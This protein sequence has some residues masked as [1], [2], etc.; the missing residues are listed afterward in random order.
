[1]TRIITFIA[2]LVVSVL[3]A[4]SKEDVLMKEAVTLFNQN[5]TEKATTLFEQIVE[6]KETD[7]LPNYY[8]A[9]INVTEAIENR[10]D[11]VKMKELL[12][13]AQAYQDK[14]NALQPENAEILLVQALI[15][16]GWIIYN[17]IINGQKLSSDVEYLYKKAT[18]L[19]PE[20]PRVILQYATYKMGKAR[21]FGQDVTPY[22]DEIK[23][24]IKLFATFKPESN[25]HPN[26]G[27]EKAT[28][29]QENCT[30]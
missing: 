3:S 2:L 21:Y 27:L 15:H 18:E 4:Q 10:E 24:A 11:L 22:C 9:L 26:W 1:M 29:A 5:E 23:E 7:W 25:L 8:L 19:A 13:T 14:A 30:K 6:T 12:E 16:T 28:K 17:P 20:N